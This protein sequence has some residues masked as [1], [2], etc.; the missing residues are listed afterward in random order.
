MAK[1]GHSAASR[2]QAVSRAAMSNVQRSTT[3]AHDPRL[4]RTQSEPEGVTAPKRVTP[5]T[6]TAKMTKVVAAP[7]NKAAEAS[8][9]YPYVLSDLKQLGIIAAAMF[10]VLIILSLIIR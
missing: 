1:K 8:I 3:V 10:A 2:R 6:D 5:R 7:S 9:Q 4:E